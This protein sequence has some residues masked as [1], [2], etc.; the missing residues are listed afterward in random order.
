MIGYMLF[1][2]PGILP[3][4]RQHRALPEGFVGLE[5]RRTGANGRAGPTRAK[6]P[7][8]GD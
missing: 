8:T 2:T 3:Q 7:D 4:K 6:K 5:R 1:F